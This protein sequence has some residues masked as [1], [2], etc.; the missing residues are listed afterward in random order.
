MK[1]TD[2]SR[3][4]W[5]FFHGKLFYA[6]Q[7]G[8]ILPGFFVAFRWSGYFRRTTSTPGIAIAVAPDTDWSG[9]QDA[10]DH[11]R[12]IYS[13]A[14]SQDGCIACLHA[15][16]CRHFSGPTCYR[17]RWA[18]VSV[19]FTDGPW[20]FLFLTHLITYLMVTLLIQ[21]TRGLRIQIRN[22][23][24]GFPIWW[25]PNEIKHIEKTGFK[26]RVLWIIRK[27]QYSQPGFKLFSFRS[28]SP[29]L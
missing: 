3:C 16:A 20:W 9:P 10:D 21:H 14:W 22:I 29:H 13:V 24:N 23:C 2:V 1:N 4:C 8:L 12:G 19:I 27:R 28:A 18:C 6:A 25:S 17:F 7:S 11:S 15:Y 5:C 26:Y